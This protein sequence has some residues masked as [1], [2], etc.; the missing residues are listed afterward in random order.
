[1]TFVKFISIA[2]AF[3]QY[4]GVMFNVLPYEPKVDYGG[5][6]YVQE[7]ITH[8]MTL[9]NKGASDYKIILGAAASASEITAASEL[10]SYLA[11]ISGVTLPITGDSTAAAAHEIIVGKTNREGNGYTIDRAGLGDEGFTL[12]VAGEKLVIAGG[13]LRGTLYGVYTFLEEQLGCRWYTE[14]LTK[15]PETNTVKI[16]AELN[17][18]QKPVFDF[19]YV[20]WFGSIEWRVKHKFNYGSQEKYGYGQYYASFCHTMDK[21]VPDSLF[22]EH[23]DYFAY[24]EETSSRTTDHACLTNPDVL[25]VAVANAR[26]IIQNARNANP[27]TSLM[28][29]GQKDNMMEC[30]CDNCKAFT[31]AHESNASTLVAFTNSIAE[32]LKDE[33][34]DIK[35]VFLAYQNT[36]TPPKDLVCRDN[37]I[38]FV[39]S[40]ES[41][42]V[43]PLNECG[44]EDGEAND[45]FEYTFSDHECRFA[46]DL[47]GWAAI[48][49]Q[50]HYYDYTINF[51]NS[52]QFFPNLATFSPNFQY[53]AE[54]KV[55]GLYESGAPGYGSQSGEFGELRQ[56]LILKLMWDPACDVEYHMM[57]FMN[58]YYGEEAAKNI[59]EYI[60]TAT[61]KIAATEHA[62]CF[63]W[64]YQIG[65][66]TVK[67]MIK[68][69][70]LW[71]NA[72]AL[73]ETPEQLAHVQRSRLQLRYYK[74]NLFMEEFNLLNPFRARENEKLYDDLVANDIHCVT[75]FSPMP[76]KEDI[77]FTLT[78]PIDWR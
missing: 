18:T 45:N 35:F 51:L 33:F 78:R 65:Y 37:V 40:I 23:P 73:A 15:I 9:V 30:Q 46:K 19:R 75:A 76:A 60:D 2:L 72:E 63:D 31:A 66:F 36:R 25:A 74:A 55:T 1:M 61:A 58:A 71:D 16:N 44:H 57:D 70:K 11:Q 6:P 22:A 24:R 8:W 56:Y 4:L 34:P 50:I 48:S 5:E 3:V 26:T 49:K 69:D 67:E 17:D 38:P 68:F 20:G 13:Q 59:K 27:Y 7:E 29:V 62:F 32:A 12:L 54:N 77:N 39:C 42:F 14:S 43:H 10:Q 28:G 53:L 21:L 64:H 52:M 41:C 47:E